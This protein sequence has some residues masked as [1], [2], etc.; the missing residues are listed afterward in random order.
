MHAAPELHILH[1]TY[2]AGLVQGGGG[3]GDNNEDDEDDDDEEDA[4]GVQYDVE[5]PEEEEEDGDE[6][7]DVRANPAL[8]SWIQLG[9]VHHMP[10]CSTID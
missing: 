9:F 5:D 7:E 2:Q 6:D 4:V 10:W 3:F 8:K 1:I